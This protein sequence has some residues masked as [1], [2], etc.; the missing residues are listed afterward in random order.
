MRLTEEGSID[1]RTDTPPRERVEPKPPPN[2]VQLA[3]TRKVG[4]IKMPLSMPERHSLRGAWLRDAVVASVAERTL[5][6]KPTKEA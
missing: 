5:S 2:Y 3:L 1:R 4:N 6:K